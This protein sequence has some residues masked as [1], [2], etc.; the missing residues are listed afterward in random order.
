MEKIPDTLAVKVENLTAFQRAY[1][2]YRAK[3]LGRSLA[4][5]KAGSKSTD[6]V[7]RS[8]IGYQLEKVDGVREYIEWL[9]QQRAQVKTLDEVGVVDL[10]KRVYDD[11]MREGKYKEANTAVGMLAEIVGL[12]GKNASPKA[13]AKRNE[14]QERQD[15]MTE[16]FQE[17]QDPSERVERL[18]LLIKDLE[19]SNK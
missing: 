18:N 7:G 1:C 10:I 19:I 4:V 6:K 17:D 9:A 13:I 11:A 15:S 3:G 5:E 12:I 14:E 16:A 2:E 8:R